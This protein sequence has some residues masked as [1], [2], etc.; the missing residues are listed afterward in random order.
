MSRIGKD[1]NLDWLRELVGKWVEH[2]EGHSY[3][4]ACPLDSSEQRELAFFIQALTKDPI[5]DDLLQLLRNH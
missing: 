5:H 4:F 1:E 2:N 3:F